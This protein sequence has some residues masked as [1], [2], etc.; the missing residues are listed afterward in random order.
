MRWKGGRSLVTWVF[1]RAGRWPD[2]T[3]FLSAGQ[4]AQRAAGRFKMMRQKLHPLRD[5]ASRPRRRETG[6][7]WWRF[8]PDDRWE[9]S[10][11]G[12][13]AS[14]SDAEISRARQP[15]QG[16]PAAVDK[17]RLSGA[18]RLLRTGQGS[19]DMNLEKAEI[20]P[21]GWRTNL[22]EKWPLLL[23]IPA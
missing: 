3:I 21:V 18:S 23:V 8:Q 22:A 15:D 16:S 7:R 2:T 19:D 4:G 6:L 5:G 9:R 20:T 14:G 1:R 10:L 13:A 17:A 11:D 12:C